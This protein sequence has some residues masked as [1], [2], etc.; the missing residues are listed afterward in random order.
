[1]KAIKYAITIIV[2]SAVAV[3][4]GHYLAGLLTARAISERIEE[5]RK[6]RRSDN[7]AMLEEMG[8]ISIGGRL[9]DFRFVDLNGDSV[10][11]SETVTGKSLVMLFDPGCGSC[12]YE[13][14]EIE[15][16]LGQS[17]ECDRFVLVGGGTPEE[18]R[19]YLQDYDI[20]CR[21]V[22]DENR[23]F[24]FGLN[25][26]GYP[27]NIVVNRELEIADVILGAMIRIEIQDFLE[28]T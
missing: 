7:A 26:P 10:L 27:F 19:T 9:N 2:C 22:C 13:I 24:I 25:V 18:I 11:L 15:N 4:A 8:T 20:N 3:G 14:E 6:T 28:T 1:M 21:V 5:A 17:G 16:V 23:E 12:G